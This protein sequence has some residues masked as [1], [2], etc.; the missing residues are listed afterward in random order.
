MV[1][2]IEKH[3][4]KNLPLDPNDPIFNTVFPDTLPPLEAYLYMPP[5][6]E[7]RNRS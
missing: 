1:E 6:N 3:K 5:Q 2:P 7:I 4:R